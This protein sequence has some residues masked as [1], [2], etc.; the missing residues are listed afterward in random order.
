V[1]LDING[2]VSTAAPR[3]TSDARDILNRLPPINAPG[4]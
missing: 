3:I 1:Q 2:L 4:H